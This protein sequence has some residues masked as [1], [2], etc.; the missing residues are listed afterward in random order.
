MSRFSD[1][2]AKVQS[3]ADLTEAEARQAIGSI[4]EGAVP[5]EEIKAFLLSLRQKGEALS[6]VVGAAL[7]LREHAA[8]FST[9]ERLAVDTCGTGGDGL[10]TMNISTLAALAAAACG[11]PV[12]KHGNRSITSACGSADLLEALGVAVDAAPAVAQRSFDETGFAFLFAPRFHPAMKAVGPVRRELGV[13]TIF[14]LLGPLTNPAR[15]RHQVV[16][17]ADLKKLDLYARALVALGAERILVVHGADGQDEISTTGSTEVAEFNRRMDPER[18]ARYSLDPGLFGIP[19]A[20]LAELKGSDPKQNAQAAQ[21]VLAGKPG[22][23]RDAVL[24]NAAAA[25]YVAGAASDLSQGISLAARALDQGKVK[26]L[27]D[28]VIRITQEK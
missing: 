23:V 17:V 19:P 24:L 27:L 8:P 6:E 1:F 2:V 28:Q 11:V 4:V 9:G 7:A 13:P 5:P 15:V 22:P 10:K 21:E 25:L 3:G 12:A 14:N 26:A 20:S 16:G 18:V